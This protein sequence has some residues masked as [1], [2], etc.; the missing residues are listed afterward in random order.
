MEIANVQDVLHFAEEYNVKFIRLQFTDALG[1]LK[2]IAITVKDLPRAL[3][4]GMIFNSSTASRLGI[5]AKSIRLTPDPKTFVIFPWRPREGAVARL[6]CDIDIPELGRDY[7]ICPRINLKMA[8]G[9][10][11]LSEISATCAFY[12]FN[13][14]ANLNLHGPN[15]T[16][17]HDQAGFCD[18]SPVDLGENVRR[19]VVLTLEEMGIQADYSRH[20]A[21]PGQH[22]IA[23]KCDDLLTLADNLVT[24]KFVVRTIA[25][26]H[27]LRASFMPQPLADLPGSGLT[28]KVEMEEDRA[29]KLAANLAKRLKSVLLFTN[30]L[31]NSYK[32]LLRMPM[33]ESIQVPSANTWE[34]AFPDLAA[35]PYLALA[36]ITVAATW[37]TSASEPD[38]PRPIHELISAQELPKDLG[39]AL[40]AAKSCLWLHESMEDG[41]L[42]WVF[43]QKEAEWNRF[44]SV[45]HCW[46]V[47]EYFANY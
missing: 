35:N 11:T 9:L 1:I 21:G 18:L 45:V 44:Q 26:R 17:V 37:E 24:F 13:E 6:L 23:F 38:E 7:D 39:E 46:E 4:E 34:L 36:A 19:D 5:P 40:Q 25:Q 27:G 3:Q 20:A 42:D 33:E 47:K 29:Q 22:E 28:L 16:E 41:L 14:G 10:P 31:V 30:P 2:N 32:R 15:R 43:S 8:A 12:L